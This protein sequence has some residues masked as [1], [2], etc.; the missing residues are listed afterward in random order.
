MEKHFKN[1]L[2]MVLSVLS[3]SLIMALEYSLGENIRLTILYIIPVGILAWNHD[4]MMAYGF[5]LLLPLCR[6]F[7]QILWQPT[8]MLQFAGMNAFIR[9]IA[10]CVYVYM[11]ALARVSVELKK[12]VKV[13]E[14]LLPICS[15]C[16]KI[17][18]ERCDYVQMESYS[19]AHSEA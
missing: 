13:L 12:E 18:N 11:I 14:G 17:R 4:I 15:S 2:A 7:Y 9:M 10:L 1:R 8:E 3:A 5:A 6:F 16:K 19:A